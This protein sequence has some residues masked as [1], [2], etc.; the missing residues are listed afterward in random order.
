M[1]DQR[2][3][4]QEAATIIGVTRTTLYK[5]QGLKGPPCYIMDDSLVHYLKSE[6]EE[7]VAANTVRVAPEEQAAR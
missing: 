5:W 7:W 2:L 1:E 3:S 4:R 6:V